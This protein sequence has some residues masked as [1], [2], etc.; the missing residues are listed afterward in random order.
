MR[1]FVV[2]LFI[3][4][5]LY[6]CSFNGL[7]SNFK[8]QKCQN[9]Y[10][11]NSFMCS[12]GQCILLSYRC[13]GTDDCTDGSDEENCD[14]YS[15]SDSSIKCSKHEYKCK[16]KNCIPIAKFCDV[17]QDCLDG[18]DEYDDCVKHLNCSGRFQCADEHCVFNEWVCDGSKDCPD[19]SDEW[20]CS[21]N[22]TSSA[23]YCK[24]E[25]SQYFCENQLCIPLKL[26]CNGKDDCGDKSDEVGCTSSCSVKCDHECKRTPKG[27]ICFCKPGYQLQNDNRTCTDID[28]CQIYGVC[29]QEC[30]NTPGSY[31]CR[32]QTDYFLQKD[33]KT[34]KAIAGEAMI[35]FSAKTEIIGM[36]LDSHI[37]FI[38]AKHLNRVIG[39][40]MNN[41]HIYWSDIEKDKEVIVRSTPQNKHEVIV[42]MGLKEISTIAVDWIT[43]NIYFTDT[44]Y[45]RIGVC[46][47]D[48]T[49]CTILINDT[50]KPTGL[51]LLP[52]HGK[53]YWCDWSSNP[54]IAVAGMDGKN[55]RIF[56]SKN[57]KAP[58]SLTI[59]YP[60][61]RLYWADIK[62]KTIETILLDGTDRRLVLHNI[63]EDPFSLAVFENKL[64][65]SDWESK[66]V[67]SCNKFTGK[68]WNLLHLG[69]HS[70]FSV[71]IDHSAIKPKVD[72]PCHSNPCSELCMLNQENGYTCACT[73]DKKLN[74]DNHTCQEVTKNLLILHD[75]I[76]T[77]YY[78]GML[79]KLKTRIASKVLLPHDIV[80]DPTSGQ[81]I[82]CVVTE[83]FEKTIVL[84]DPVSDTFKN[85]ILHN[86][87]YFSMAFD[88]IGN[89]LYMT[90][91]PSNS[92]N[93]YNVKTLA[94]T[95][96]YF[97][98]YVPYYITLV[99]EESKMYVAFK[100]LLSS[101]HTFERF[102]IYEMEMNGLGEKKL[103]RD[104]LHGPV[105]SMYYDRDSKM[106][107]VSDQMS[108]N[109]LSL[110]IL[111]AED[112]RL[113]RTG[114][115]QPVSLTVADDNIF[116]IE[117]EKNSDY[118]TLYSTNFKSSSNLNHKD[119]IL[120]I[121]NKL[122][123]YPT[124]FPRVIT[125]RK[126]AKQDHDC[127]KNNGN[128]SHICL[129]SSIT[130]FVCACPP[131]M[132][133]SSNNRTCV[134]YECS[135][136]EFKCGEHNVCIQ[137]EN[138]CDGNVHCPNG[139]DETIDCHK[140]KKCKKDEFTCTNGEC[141]SI[142][143]RCNWHYD[144][145]DQS[146]EENCVKP[147][148]TSDEFQCHNGMIPCIS[149]SLLCDGDFDCEDGSDE[150]FEACKSSC[151]NDKFQCNN[152]NCISLLLKCN[153]IDDCLD[154]SDERHCL[155]KSI[156]LI[157]CTADKYQCLDTDLCLPKKVKCDG[158]SDCPKNDDEHNCVFCF[159]NEFTCDN[160]EC[161]LENWVCDKF[162]DC[163]DNSDEKNC[164][165]SKKIIMESTKCDEFKCSIGTCL[166]YSKVCDGNRD[167]PDGSDENGKC[168]IACMV[169]NFCKGL[170]YKTPKG[171]VCGCPYG[172]RLA[173]DATSCEDINECEND[174]CSQFCRNTVG[175]FEC[176]CQEGYY[177]R[178]KVSC[179][180]IGPAMEFITVTDNDIRKISSNLHSIDKIY[181]LSGLSINGLDVNAVHNSIY[182]SNGEFGT[183]KK[184][185][186]KTKKITTIKIVE[187][188][189]SLAVDWITNNVYVSDNGHLNTIKVCNLEE[190]KCATLVEIE[191]KAKIVSIVVDSINRWLFWA[192][193]TWQVDMPFSKICRTDMMGADMK[194][195]GSDISFVSGIA[196]DH[197]KS[198]LYWLDSFS[199][200]IESSNLDGSQRSMFLRTNMY[201]PFGISI[202]EQS[203][204]WLMDTSG[205]L[206]SCKLYGKKSCET[207]N[208]GKNNVH[209]QFAI[210]HISRQP[211][212]KNP[213]DE[214]YCDHMCVLKKENATCICL[215]GKSIESNSICTINMNNGR[216][217]FKNPMRSARYTSG[218]YSL[219]IIVLV[220]IVLLLCI[221]YYYQKNRLKSKPINNLS[222][223]SI[224]FHNPSY[225][226]SNEVEV[227]LN[228]I[229]TGLS[230]GQHEYINPIDNK[231]LNLKDA[232]E[233][234]ENKQRSDLYSKERDIEETE[235]Q[236][237]LIYFV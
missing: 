192:Q 75:T 173:A 195:I 19:G 181:S 18:S 105:I 97:K 48:G 5:F 14:D 151:S 1:R 90:N 21:A 71:H 30:I 125:L 234:S 199:K 191:D 198:K 157:N 185:N 58:Q 182:W 114:L 158:K 164:D 209:K 155:V 92:I 204:Y 13:D 220:V 211:V 110:N 111:S 172:Y 228:S 224:H 205:Q 162:N 35:V 107:F 37:I 104:N 230:P 131:G 223:S 73:L 221:F 6:P 95:V 72:N 214:K 237:S 26:V 78:H 24:I 163:G 169:N 68:D 113:L 84:F 196:I 33:K 29:D 28:E 8:I 143:N 190:E 146:D 76:F 74:V 133:L 7:D 229:V 150:R 210:L 216:I 187:H 140:N 232:M 25:N 154:G 57:L 201:Y 128:C 86:V 109:I 225:D 31:S 62:S 55:I 189:Q 46:K 142:K 222:C 171:D 200:T 38:I 63:I 108:G 45:N 180:A 115:R 94:M 77:N 112:A 52:T 193:I 103:L 203:L 81:V 83:Q 136:N 100:N 36:Y 194:I 15:D 160:K 16:N 51:V 167:C 54:H 231:F 80:S 41:D 148:C 145:T 129:L 59:D 91:I 17:I 122:D 4:S 178:N 130:S 3:Y 219:I 23:S 88:H 61:N 183:I 212:D 137:K 184:L 60:T 22:E 2:L 176:S 79:G 98:E 93:V 106:L 27:N 139:E 20:N 64:Y 165:G 218:V 197:I 156:Y 123:Y 174:I 141:V 119:V 177:L 121:S 170:C 153:G 9:L 186:I 117:Y 116:W 134:V 12:N 96:F 56:V 102:C 47:D 236:D 168:Q 215:D 53:I 101:D 152:G 50:E 217:S 66:S 43:Q 87:S 85:T 32:C 188:P 70:H 120:H 227:T 175:S 40:A 132:S 213:C 207:I 49:Y 65:W 144:C 202:Y 10:G 89:N 179:K 39:V 127:Q 233:N 124:I 135:K 161:I 118:S 126:D 138:V 206:Q 159:D 82:C 208:I 69:Q 67:E 34:C 42:M 11:K 226:R 147:K 149:K 44:G 235:K 99:P 166:P